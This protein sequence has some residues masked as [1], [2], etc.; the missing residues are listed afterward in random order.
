VAPE[1]SIPVFRVR[2]PHPVDEA[3]GNPKDAIAGHSARG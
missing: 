3:C 2:N 1:A